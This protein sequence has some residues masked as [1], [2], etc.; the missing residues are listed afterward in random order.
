MSVAE[1][2]E[3]PAETFREWVRHFDLGR[4]FVYDLLFGRLASVMEIIEE[5]N[6]RRMDVMRLPSSWNAGEV[7]RRSWMRM[8]V[9]PLDCF[10]LSGA[11]TKC[12]GLTKSN[13]AGKK[14]RR[15]PRQR[16]GQSISKLELVERGRMLWQFC[17]AEIQ[18]TY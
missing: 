2:L 3:I 5:V 7:C 4:E 10:I 17:Q 8:I 15:L 13:S 18:T 14:P 6:F 9:M 16:P 12:V 11:V 1:C